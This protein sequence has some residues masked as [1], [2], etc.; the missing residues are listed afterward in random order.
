M[1][2]ETTRAY[3]GIAR[4]IHWSMAVLVLVMVP[5]GVAI[6][7]EWV[8]PVLYDLHKTLGVIL[9]ALILVRIAYRLTHKPAPL[10]PDIAPLQRLAAGTVHALLYTLLLVQPFIGWI[11]TSAYPA[12]VPFFRLFNMPLIWPANRALSDQL[13]VV[14]RT[15]G[16]TIGI[17]ALMHIGA[18]LHHHFVRRDGVL[19]RML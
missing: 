10:P 15:I 5:L 9:A 7:N 11:A 18:A 1:S 8:G 2:Q 16:V 12:P 14:H 17:L 6:A 19:R 13:F 4:T 3:T